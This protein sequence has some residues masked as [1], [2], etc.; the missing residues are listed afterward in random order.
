MKAIHT[1]SQPN[2]STKDER[3]STRENPV[4]NS[5]SSNSSSI[6]DS[7]SFAPRRA[8]KLK[9]FFG[10]FS[11]HNKLPQTRGGGTSLTGI[12]FEKETPTKK[13]SVK[14]ETKVNSVSFFVV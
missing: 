11:I 12:S 14:N 6:H 8:N 5:I 2:I 13:T 4:S 1:K 7:S 10:L 9:E 3:I